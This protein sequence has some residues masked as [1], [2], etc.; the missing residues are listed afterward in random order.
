[1][2]R[3][4]NTVSLSKDSI[5]HVALSLIAE[6]GIDAFSIRDVARN[7]ETYPSAIY[8]YFKN[9]NALLGGLMSDAMAAVSP[10]EQSLAWDVWLHQLF[11]NYRE[12]VKQRPYMAELIG[13]RLLS[14]AYQEPALLEGILGALEQAGFSSK[15]I[16][17]LYNSVISCM[18]GFASME[19][20]Q[21]PKE[22]QTEWEEALRTGAEELSEASYPHLVKHLPTMLNQAF[23]L[24]WQNGYDN[25]LDDSFD[26]YVRIFIDGLKAQRP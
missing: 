21:L 26:Q 16:V 2:K 14:N 15:Q 19:F 4:E 9:K 12:M 25:P 13:G 8:W 17:P 18:C 6:K 10:Q 22:D 3:K 20:G 5:M 24:R 11:Y 23:V 1:M 7:M